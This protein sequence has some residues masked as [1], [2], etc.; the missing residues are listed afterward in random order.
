MSLRGIEVGHIFYFGEKYSAPMGAVSAGP[1]GANAGPYG[2]LWHRLYASC[3]GG[4]IEASHDDKGIIWPRAV[5]PFDVAVVNL[6]PDDE[7][8]SSCAEDFVGKLVN[9]ALTR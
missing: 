5:A 4:I 6:K 1:D 3:R 9:A 8:S 2:V 7:T